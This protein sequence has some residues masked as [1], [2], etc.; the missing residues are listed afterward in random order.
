MEWRR[1]FY[2]SFATVFVFTVLQ[3][4]SVCS[5]IELN[6]DR[7]GMTGL[8]ARSVRTGHPRVFI[9]PESLEELKQRVETDRREIYTDI[10]NR[11]HEDW[12]REQMNEVGWSARGGIEAWGLLALLTED[13]YY[14]EAIEEQF[15][16]VSNDLPRNQYLTPSYLRGLSLVYDWTHSLVTPEQR[17]RRAE[18]LCRLADYCRTIWRHNDFNNHFVAERMVVLYPGVVLHA[19]G[20]FPDKVNSYLEEGKDFWLNHAIPAANQMAGQEGGHAEGFSYAGWGYAPHIA[21]AAELWRTAF[22][23]DL[24]PEIPFLREYAAWNVHCMRPQDGAVVRSEDCH[25]GYKGN[26]GNEGTYMALLA[27]RYHDGLAQ[28]ILSRIPRRYPQFRW[29]ELLWHEPSVPVAQPESLPLSRFFTGLG[30]V[31]TRSGWGEDDTMAMFQC[32]DFYAG[33]QHVDNN[34]FVIHRGG[35]LAID[36]GVYDES[37]H[38]ANYFCRSVAHNTITVFDPEEQ[39]SNAT[40][41]PRGTGGSNDGGQLRGMPAGRFGEVFPGSQ[42][43]VGEIISYVAGDYFTYACGDATRAYSQNKLSLFTRGFLHI[44]PH[45]FIIF[46]RVVSTSA[47]YK[48]RWLLHSID[49]PDVE[50]KTITITQGKGKLICQT[51]LPERV[52]IE[53]VGGPGREFWVNGENYPPQKSDP[54]AGAWRVEIS[55]REEKTDDVFLHVLVTGDSGLTEIIPL[56][57]ERDDEQVRIEGEYMGGDI[58]CVFLLKEAPGGR[59]R[60]QRGGRV[61]EADFNEQSVK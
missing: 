50:G 14:L 8:V 6:R 4:K 22:G 24:Y 53:K 37:P 58:E 61:E 12:Y 43:D 15:T 35:A 21:F 28:Y 45:L 26:Q 32:G 3:P 30:W 31:V 27:A 1:C 59:I 20:Y 34:S 42:H 29:G 17:E 11:L 47:D 16:A 56:R 36:S 55:P 38:R 2:L 19:D 40:W 57:V 51:L 41:S 7:N 49:E 48:K 46:D 9:T 10:V 60:V 54:E 39:F 5:Q 33:H 18:V 52:S 23:Q 13:P 25:S 44:R